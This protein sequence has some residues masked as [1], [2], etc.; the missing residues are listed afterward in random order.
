MPNKKK[1][2][3]AALQNTVAKL[4]ENLD[5][6]YKRPSQNADAW[7]AA[8]NDDRFPAAPTLAQRFFLRA[9][10]AALLP[11]NGLSDQGR[12]PPCRASEAGRAIGSP[13]AAGCAVP[14]AAIFG[15]CAVRL[16]PCMC[17]GR[18]CLAWSRR[19]QILPSGRPVC[20]RRTSPHS[21]RRLR[22]EK[23]VMNAHGGVIA[24]HVCTHSKG[25]ER[26]YRSGPWVVCWL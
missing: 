13:A 23:T 16:Q 2:V 11:G 20:K 25:P 4:L 26:V 14:I 17:F 15:L 8:V 3:P 7:R 1:H 19:R 21:A 9:A 10:N 24:R 12:N 22:P 6:K 5:I 18:T